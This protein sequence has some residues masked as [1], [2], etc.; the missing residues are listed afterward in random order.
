L[1]SIAGTVDGGA[2]EIRIEPLGRM[3]TSDAAGNFV[4]RSLPPGTFTITAQRGGR[5][6][7]RTVTVPADPA[8][9]KA[10]LNLSDVAPPV[11]TRV[12]VPAAL[13]TF[14]VQLG[15]F[16]EPR[17][18]AE[19]IHR[20]AASG[21]RAE[22]VQSDQLILVRVGPFASRAEAAKTIAQLHEQ[23]FDA[24]VTR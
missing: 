18:A 16:R 21:A 4:F 9:L 17:N 22:S 24:I 7:S 8:V 2:A 10:A 5:V 15:A 11:A 13:R 19:L 14:F 3:I 23:G 12:T 20:I 1:R 6:A